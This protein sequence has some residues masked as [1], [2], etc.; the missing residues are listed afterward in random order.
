MEY[1]VSVDARDG[2]VKPQDQFFTAG[3]ASRA[4]SMEYA[5]IKSNT[6]HIDQTVSDPATMVTG[7]VI[8]WIRENSHCVL[9]KKTSDGNVA[10]CRLKDDGTKYHD[11]SAVS[12]DGTEGDVFV[13][14]PEFYYKGTEGDR[15]DITFAR[16]KIDDG[17]VKWDGNTLIGAYEGCIIDG[18]AYSRSG[19]A[20]T[21]N[22]SQENWKKQA[23][24]RSIGYQLVDWQMHC[25]MCCLYYAT[26]GNTNC[27][28]EIGAG[29]DSY[30]KNTRR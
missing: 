29:T 3:Q 27:Q 1:T 28:K 6:V 26:R 11:G 12:L 19:V 24:T 23:R 8:R 17:Y 25:V 13:K 15:A 10:Y 30:T 14:L 9:A 4:V 21:G 16:E 7:E 18:K 22:V 5:L 20:S 2:Y